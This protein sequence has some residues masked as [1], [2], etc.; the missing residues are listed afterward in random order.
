VKGNGFFEKERVSLMCGRF[1]LYSP[2]P[3]IVET[4]HIQEVCAQFEPSYNVAPTHEVA[5]VVKR[6]AG[7]VLQTMTWGLIP[8]WAKDPK[9]GSRMINARVETLSQKPSFKRPLKTQRCLI[10]ADGFFEWAKTGQAKVPMF[11]RPKSKQPFG[12]AGLYDVWQSPAGETVTSCTIITTHANDFMQPIHSRMP[13]ILANAE[14][15]DWL[16]LATPNIDEWLSGLHPYPSHE[17]EA[18]QVSRQVNSPAHNNID[19]VQPIGQT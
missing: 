5:V 9:I 4:F 7:N 1:A 16:D 15:A 2:L 14:Q 12:F 8:F 18:Y 6:E 13:L 10:V 11:I 3:E 19:C 17:L